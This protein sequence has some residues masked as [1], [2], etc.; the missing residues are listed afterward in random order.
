MVAAGIGFAANAASA[1]LGRH[2]NRDTTMSPVVVT[3]VSMAIG[4]GV[5]VVVGVA[6]EGVPRVGLRAGLLVAW[7]A[8]V[9]TAAA[10]TLWN[11]AQ[12]HLTALE[13]TGINNTM[14]VQIAVLAWVFL[15]EPPGV[16]GIV[17]ILVVTTGVVLTQLPARAGT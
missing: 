9:N 17:G 16:S 11:H 4:A 8:L 12:R 6:V 13:S 15:G 10:F 7:L 1:V 2:V 3:A 14:L 5:L